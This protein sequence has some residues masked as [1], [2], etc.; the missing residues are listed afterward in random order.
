MHKSDEEIKQDLQNEISKL[1]MALKS[2]TLRW[3]LGF[4]LIP[5]F[6][7][8]LLLF[9]ISVYLSFAGAQSVATVSLTRLETLGS[10]IFTVSTTVIGLIIGFLPIIGFFYLG[11]IKEDRKKIESSLLAEKAGKSDDVQQMV[12]GINHL[13]DVI[14][15]LLESAV[16][17]YMLINVIASVLAV[18][19]IIFSYVSLGIT[20]TVDSLELFII[21]SIFAVVPIVYGIFPLV[22]LAFY[23]TSYKVIQ[24]RENGRTLTLIIP[25]KD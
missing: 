21:V 16:K 13:Y 17:K 3:M 9:L 12:D 14:T 22:A 8:E 24:Q 5:P 15:N 1:N 7:F 4:W 20:G 10:D 18:F 11:E 23:A 6:L 19:V 25:P 2:H